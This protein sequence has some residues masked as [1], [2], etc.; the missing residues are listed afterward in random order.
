MKVLLVQP[1][2]TIFRTESK[3][4]HPPIGMAYLAASLKNN[5]EVRVLDALAEGCEKNEYLDQHYLRY[6]LSFEEI[7]KKIIEFKPDVVGVSCLFSA[8]TE[9]VHRVFQICKKVNKEIITVIGG[10]HPSSVPRESLLDKNLDFAI[11]GEGEIILKKLLEYIENKKDFSELEGIGFKTDGR[12]NILPRKGYQDNIDEIPFPYWDIF[13][14]EKYFKIN[15][16][17]GN[18]AKRVPYLPVVT[19]RGCPFNCIF[20]SVHN[21]WGNS[22]RKRSSE[23]VLT[24]LEYL[25]SKFGVREVLFED[26][27]LTFDYERSKNIFQGIIDKKIDLTWSTPNGI[28]IQTLDDNLLELMKK[29]GC[30]SI[31]IGVESGDESI[32]KN[33]IEKPIT[34]AKIKPIISKAKVLGLET[35]AFFVVGFPQEGLA[36]IKNT[37]SFARN[38][39]TD[40]TNFFFATPLPG[41]RLLELCKEKGLTNG[42]FVYSRLKSDEPYL[43]TGYLTKDE[44][45]FIVQQEMLKLYFLNFL[46]NPKRFIFK[47]CYKLLKEPAY[48]VRFSLRYSRGSRGMHQLDS[49]AKATKRT[50]ERYSFLWKGAVN[51]KPDKWHYNNMQDVIKEPIVRGQKGIDV[52]SGCGYDTYIMAKN[53]PSVKIVSLDISEGVYKTKEITAGLGNVWILRGSALNI[54]IADNSLDFAYSFGVLHHTPDPEQGVREI[55]RVIKKNS[56]AYL[57]LYEDHSDN[58]VKYLGLKLVNALR[59][60]TT[61]VPPRV[62]YVFSFLASPL[63]IIFFTLPHRILKKFKATEAMSERIPFNFGTHPFSLAG[64]LYDRFAAPVEHRFSKKG[65]FDLLNHNGF[66]N[67][68]LGRIK[69]TAGWVAWGVK[70]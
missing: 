24:E 65:I 11:I 45:S 44:L 63:A 38:L 14:L 60:I 40:N 35:T 47:F 36:N 31:S 23:N 52:G 46:R 56:P 4:C 7:E 61:K 58:L 27:N 49:F 54:P 18:P 5:F 9:N 12:I 22:Y 19:S 1:P 64:D 69:A 16:P 32:L 68:S 59:L 50:Q 34:L 6:G 30:Y 28:A 20:C 57:Y 10:A 33:I 55:A 25:V 21:L 15:N 66:V 70:G 67:I 37:F 51:H 43:D 42:D 53:N 8:Q 41:T 13:P 39:K 3:K 2:F 48:F 26:D 17:H 29:S 62:L